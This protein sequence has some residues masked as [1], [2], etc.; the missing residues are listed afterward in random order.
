MGT[1]AWTNSLSRSLI[2]VSHSSILSAALDSNLSVG[3]LGLEV[4][5]VG[6][7]LASAAVRWNWGE[8][9]CINPAWQRVR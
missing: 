3:C 4:A 5:S 2:V 6:F 1:L 9:S 8:A 7:D